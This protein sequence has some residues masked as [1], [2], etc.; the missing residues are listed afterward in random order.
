VKRLLG[1]ALLIAC[2]LPAVALAHPRATGATRAAIERA[3]FAGR[4]AVPGRHPQ[5]CVRV[6][7]TTVGG[8]QWATLVL[9]S[10]TARCGPPADNEVALVHRL[11]VR[12]RLVGGGSAGVNCVKLHVPVAVRHDLSLPCTGIG[13]L[14][15]ADARRGVGHR[16][17]A[18]VSGF[19]IY[20]LKGSCRVAKRI[21]LIALVNPGHVRIR[22]HGTVEVFKGWGCGLTQGA[23]F[24]GTPALARP[25]RIKQAFQGL[26]CGDPG[27]PVIEHVPVNY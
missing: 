12:W 27:C 11:H 1:I 21:A 26:A 22:Q 25:G 4:T 6:E 8:G 5:S 10:G 19:G 3:V 23:L 7:V 2:V 17:C 13:D 16:R 14:V 15:S 9:E 24:C 18:K 20:P